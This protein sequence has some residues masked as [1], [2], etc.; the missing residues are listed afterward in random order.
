MLAPPREKKVQIAL[1]TK[2]V[3]WGGGRGCL[4]TAVGEW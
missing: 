1:G 4:V 2:T 3:G